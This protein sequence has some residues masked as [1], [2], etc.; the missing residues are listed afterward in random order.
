MNTFALALLAL[1][2]LLVLYVKLNDAKL[3]RLPPEAAHISPERWTKEQ[4]KSCYAGLKDGPV[5]ILEGQLPP[6][7]GRR[8]IVV[9]GAGFLGGWIVLHLLQRGEDPRKIRVLDIRPPL[10]QDLLEGLAQ[11]VDFVQVDITDRDA[12]LEAFRQPWPNAASDVPNTPEPDLTV[13]HTAATIRFYERHSHLLYLSE[14]VNVH[15]TQNIIDAARDVGAS[16]MVYT[17]SGSVGVRRSCF[18]LLPWQKEPKYFT[19]VINDDDSN[20]PKQHDQFFSNYAVSKLTAER[21][22]RKADRSESSNGKVLRTG[23]IRP[24]NGV[25]GPGGDL[26]AGAYMIKKFNPTWIGAIMQSF[27]YVENCSLAHLLYEQRLIELENGS[28]NPDIGGEAF[29][30]ADPGPPPT[31]SDIHTA[32]EVLS[33][34]EVKFQNL[35][36]T[37]MLAIA[38]LVEWYYLTR[39]FLVKSSFAFLGNLLP[40]I[41]GDVVFLQPS[42][43]ALTNVHLYFDDSRARAPPEK[44]GLGYTSPCRTLEGVCQVVIDHYRNGGKGTARIIA[45]HIETSQSPL[46]G[47]ELAVGSAMEKISDGLDVTKALN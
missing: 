3:E 16:A 31:Y 44:G 42:M 5:S 1:P 6:R 21:R 33:D 24:G 11:E 28:K 14:N 23:C 18:W 17:S 39:R 43:F 27:S 36:P 29:C 22:V 8:Y 30:I 25:Y 13:F 12:V 40:Q 32:L 9:G 4:I 35:S 38:H 2:L 26:L 15:G 41:I 19:Q 37:S 7:T 46:V 47:A 34:G 20:L 45:G 10:R